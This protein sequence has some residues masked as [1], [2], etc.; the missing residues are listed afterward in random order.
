MN[1]I[2]GMDTKVSRFLSMAWNLIVL[3]LLTLLG[4]LP[5][6]TAG[7]SL[8][9]M[10]YVLL[11]LVRKEE[12]YIGRMFRQ[13]FK[14]NFRQSTILW[15]L[16]LAVFF[17]YRADWVLAEN[18]PETFGAPMKYAVVI[19]AILTFMLMQF[20]FPLQSHFANRLSGTVKNAAILTISKFPRTLVMT[21]VWV[22]PYE[23]LIHSMALL[24]VLFMLGISLPGYVCARM[25]EPVF[26]QLE[27]EKEFSEMEPAEQ[28][29]TD[30]IAGNTGAGR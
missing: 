4:C 20:V 1:R 12:S 25:Y 30:P 14:E 9:A 27:P 7:A 8:T 10:H 5:I 21:L 17:L 13:A 28:A 16:F 2:F 29:A 15:L 19:L 24:P 3:N 26:E 11:K 22:I 23:T 18:Y 6:V